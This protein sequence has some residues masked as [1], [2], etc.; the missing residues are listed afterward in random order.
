MSSSHLI[1]NGQK[2]NQ[3]INPIIIL[4]NNLSTHSVLTN[5]NSINLIMSFKIWL[6]S[7]AIAPNNYIFIVNTIFIK[8]V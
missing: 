3:W 7:G 1:M 5:N 2:K 8:Q 4:E 6:N